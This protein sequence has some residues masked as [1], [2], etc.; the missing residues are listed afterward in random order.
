MAHHVG[1]SVTGSATS[2]IMGRAEVRN[3]VGGAP[4]REKYTT[5]GDEA[6]GGREG[7]MIMG[8]AKV[9]LITEFIQKIVTIQHMILD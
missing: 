4:R 2:S 3:L 5:R 7:G 8:S 9:K 6:R 1:G